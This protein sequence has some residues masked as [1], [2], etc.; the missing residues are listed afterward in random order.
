MA[1]ETLKGIKEISRTGKATE[2]RRGHHYLTITE[3]EDGHCEIEVHKCIPQLVWHFCDEKQL[4]EAFEIFKQL[5][6]PN[7]DGLI[8]EVITR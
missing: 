8:T 3:W 7:D 1:L 6:L 2:Y 4:E 5:P